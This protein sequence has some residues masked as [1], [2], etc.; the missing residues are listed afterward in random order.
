MSWSD[1]HF[2][3]YHYI[4]ELPNFVSIQSHMTVLSICYLLFTYTNRNHA[5]DYSG[6]P[7]MTI[8]KTEIEVRM[9]QD[10]EKINAHADLCEQISLF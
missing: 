5:S 7:K 6:Y 4:V 1:L 3:F 2:N 9:M 10:S 8:K